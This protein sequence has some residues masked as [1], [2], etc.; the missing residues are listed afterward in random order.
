VLLPLSSLKLYSK[1]CSRTLVPPLKAALDSL[2]G[3]LM[4]VGVSLGVKINIGARLLQL[5]VGR[6]ELLR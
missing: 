5:G 3:K 6:M 2:T 4:V 1:G